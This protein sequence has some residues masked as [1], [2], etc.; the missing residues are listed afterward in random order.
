MRQPRQLL[1]LALGQ[2]GAHRR[3]D[4][5]EPR[6]AEREHVGVALDDDRPLLLRDR[7]PR[8]VEPVEQVALAEEL[9]LG[10]VDVLRA[11]RVVLA[12]LARLE[13]AHPAARVGEREEQP[14]REVV[15]AAPVDEPG[16]GELRRGEALLARL[17]RQGRAAGREPEPVLAADLFAEPAALEVRARRP[18][19]L[20]SPRG[21][22]RR[23]SSPARAAPAAAR[24]GCAPRRAPARTP[25][26]RA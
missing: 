9:A 3:D 17:A 21:S 22:A 4:R 26:T 14:P 16:G 7:R 25:R 24:A 1:E 2:R 13:A 23:S 20:A 6:L 5:L 15:V 11:Q 19:R 10:R 12:Q 18:A 8:A